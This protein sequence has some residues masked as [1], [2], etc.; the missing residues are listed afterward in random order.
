MEIKL[1]EQLFEQR[2]AALESART[3]SPRLISRLETLIR[4]GDDAALFRV[5]PLRFAAERNM[6]EAEA[7]D[8]FLHAA[9]NGL[10]RMDWLLLCPMCA[11]VV[12]SLSTLQHVGNHYFCPMCRC[13]YESTLD[14]FVAVYF[15]I[16]PEIRQIAFHHPKELS[17]HDYCFLYRMTPDGHLPNGPPLGDVLKSVSIGVR[18]LP[19][20]E[21]TRFE[22]EVTGGLFFGWDPDGKGFLQFPIAGLPSAALQV[23]RV[24]YD[25]NG[26]DPSERTVAP[27]KVVFELENR[28][29]RRRLFSM[30]VIPPGVERM[31][32]TF[33]PFLRG[34]RLLST[35]TFRTLFR[36]ELVKATE[37]IGVRDVTLIFTDLKGSTALYERIGDLNAFSL[38]QQHFERLLDVTVQHN[39]AVIKTLGDAV[40][41][42]FP[43]PADAVKAATAM[44]E[45][46]DRF[47]Q[48]RQ[49]QD[50][51]LKIGIHRGPSI[52]VTLNERLDYF[53][54]TVNIAA[55]VQGL[56]DGGEICCTADVHD[57]AGI[58]ELLAPFQVARGHAQLKGVN[59]E[60]A[61]FRIGADAASKTG[62]TA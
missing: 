56:A 9:A 8:L 45:E 52:A 59:Q 5:N 38:V 2:I 12:E 61:V 48:Q 16:S 31:M 46:I 22:A 10:F 60:M 51:I 39:G 15:T 14:E 40:M 53:G 36:S 62:A 24:R 32:L 21:I 58:S 29:D 50:L 20:G 11:C 17:A 28:T 47:N 18:Y 4:T 1:N 6:P 27:G 42:V 3:W 57:A 30:G 23:I 54:Q 43:A 7:I 25:E 34:A 41:A 49:G 26:C 37:G 44:R 19:P 35:Q 33:D 13:D 55:R